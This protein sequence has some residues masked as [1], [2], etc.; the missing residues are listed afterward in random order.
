MKSK[1]IN[2]DCL[3]ALKEM[4]DNS[5]DSIVSDP[6]YGISF[7]GKKWDYDVPSIEVWQECLRVLKPGGHALIACGTR[8]QHRMA[9]NLED[10]GFIIKD[11]IFYH[12]G[13][14]FPKSHR[15]GCNCKR[16][17]INCI[18]GKENIEL[19]QDLRSVPE[20]VSVQDEVSSEKKSDL[21]SEVRGDFNITKQDREKT[22]ASSNLQTMQEG[23]LP[24]IRVKS[25]GSLLL[26]EMQ[27]DSE[28]K[29]PNQ[30]FSKRTGEEVSSEGDENGKE[31]SLERRSNLLEEKGKLQAD[32]VY[33][34]SEG[35]SRNGEKG[36]LHNGT[37]ANNGET[38]REITNKQG[39]SS[40]HRPQ[41]S[42]QQDKQSN[43][44][45]DKSSP[46]EIRRKCE[47]CGGIIGMEGFGSALK[48]STE[49]WTLCYKP[50]AEKT[51]RANVLK[52]GTGGIN[53]DGCRVEG[54]NTEIHSN[55]KR[56]MYGGNSLLES[57]THNK[58]TEIK[59]Y[60]RFPANLLHDGSDEVVEGFPDSNAT[61]RN[62]IATR[63]EDSTSFGG[64]KG[65]EFTRKEFGD[66]GS[67]SRFFYCAKAS[68]AE[69]NKGLDGFEES[70]KAGKDFRPNHTE[71][72]EQGEDGN[73]F[74]RWGK[75]K[76]NHPTIKPIKLMRYLCRLITPKG[77]TILDPYVGSGST[78]IGAKLE[79]FNF[80]GIER[81]KEYCKI[82]EARIKGWEKDLTLF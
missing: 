55:G 6:P 32:K 44:I 9:V 39:G 41:P 30:V 40:S 73:A 62:N 76:N 49:I 51:I 59:N 65:Q 2:N 58:K 33:E 75:I 14:G 25:E 50:M 5:I 80:I 19:Q 8:T 57:K 7:M 45:S 4:E 3:I 72:A 28:V 35:I 53:I 70:D 22:E 69:R 67:A 78:G 12:Y 54:E 64:V 1:I 48:P 52:Y 37:Q 77:G 34:V 43:V 42:Q 56:S 74:G 17:V 46:Q 13:S 18:Y 31:S 66:S 15:V 16:D 23:V 10:G 26:S 82:A 38:S 68:K 27:R 81:E 47:V 61:N 36:Q 29:E 79:G 20:G 21:L 60:G 71:K 24:E 11:L 63:K